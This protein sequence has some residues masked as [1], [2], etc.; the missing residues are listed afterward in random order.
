[1]LKKFGNAC[2]SMYSKTLGRF[3]DREKMVI[4]SGAMGMGL[5]SSVVAMGN[6]HFE[7]NKAVEL[8]LGDKDIAKQIYY[9]ANKDGAFNKVVEKLAAA[10]THILGGDIGNDK[11]ADRYIDMH[12]DNYFVKKSNADIPVKKIDEHIEKAYS[13]SKTLYGNTDLVEASNNID[14]DTIKQTYKKNLN[15]NLALGLVIKD[16]IKKEAQKTQTPLDLK[17]EKA[18]SMQIEVAEFKDFSAN[19]GKN[20]SESELKK[21]YEGYIDIKLSKSKDIEQVKEYEQDMQL[22]ISR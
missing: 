11:V 3:S 8:A 1:M 20:M 22:S 9:E 16:E 14:A 5:V 18:K 2:K 15:E 7:T 13:V 6:V 10:G 17:I 4:V 21:L 12:S 19:L